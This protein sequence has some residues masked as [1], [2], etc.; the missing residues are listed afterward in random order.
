MKNLNP[1]HGAQIRRVNPISRYSGLFQLARVL[2]H[3]VEIASS[4]LPELL[5]NFLP[6]LIT[7][8]TNP[9][10]DGGMQIVRVRPK[11]VPHLFERFRCN[12]GDCPSP[13]RVHRRHRAIPLIYQQQR[14]AVGRLDRYHT[15]R[16]IL[17]QRIALPDQARPAFGRDAGG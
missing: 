1:A 14:D 16:R 4:L 13:S 5:H 12:P 15:S 7:A 3:K 8:L 10:P 17:H 2:F 11:P 9:R 6:N